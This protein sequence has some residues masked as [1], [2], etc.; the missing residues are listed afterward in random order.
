VIEALGHPAVLALTATASPAMREE[1]LTRLGM[2]EP[3]V[4]VQGFDRPNIW[5]GV[6]TVPSALARST[7]S[8]HVCWR[9]TNLVLCMGP[10][11]RRLR[12]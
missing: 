4:I 3:R 6:E 1:I 11:A 10:P 7:P 8:S 9:P 5:L 12:R 2:R